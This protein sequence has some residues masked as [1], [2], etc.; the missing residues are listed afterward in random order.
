MNGETIGHYRILNKLGGGGMG[1]VYEAEDLNL[2]RRVALKFLPDEL[3]ADPASLER[4]E[5]EARLASSLNHPGICTIHDI[6]DHG[7]KRYIVMELMEGETLKYLIQRGAVPVD[8]LLDYA[9]QI[10][11]AL[12][13][14][15]EAGVV[16]RDIKPANIFV[17]RR[18]HVKVL[19]FGL[20]KGDVPSPGA[21]SSDTALDTKSADHL[22]R[23]GAALGTVAYM[24]PEQARG[25]PLDPRTDLFSFGVVLYEMATGQLP[26]QGQT[27]AVIFEGIL[28]KA[29]TAPVALNP[30]LPGEIERIINTALEKDRQTRYQHADD[31]LADLKRLRRDTSSGES[32]AHVAAVPVATGA[33]DE[34]SMS[35]SAVRAARRHW[36]LA[37]P[38]AAVVGA[39]TI[40]LV[41]Q[42]REGPALTDRDTILL[43]D[44]TNTTGEDV[45]DETL[46]QALRVQLE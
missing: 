2:G 39:A 31:L 44:F 42:S 24:S 32:R 3:A 46:K 34:L 11:E 17:T 22:T 14:A 38:L 29:A 16:H 18:G 36:K 37:L 6:G 43:T 9:T 21:V 7:G 5:R 20:A 33:D 40:A 26:F 41:L 19:D 30:D 12:A 13:A 23:P 25:E 15:H 8:R 27:S 4:F 45:F 35:R 1:V 28:S 10:A